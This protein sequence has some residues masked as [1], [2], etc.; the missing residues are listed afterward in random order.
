MKEIKLVGIDVP[1]V[2][3]PRDDGTQGSALYDVPIILSDTPPT[4]WAVF[5]EAAYGMPRN[6]KVIGNRIVVQRTTIEQVARDDEKSR[7]VAAVK[8][9][10]QKAQDHLEQRAKTQEQ[11]RQSDAEF[12]KHVQDVSETIKFD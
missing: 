7:L 10:N 6:A 1:G 3:A 8:E 9:A 12:R 11:Q 5:F 2:T 4:D